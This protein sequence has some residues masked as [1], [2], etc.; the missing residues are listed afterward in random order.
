MRDKGAN[1][2]RITEKLNK[3]PSSLYRE[4]NRNIGKI[5]YCCLE[6]EEK[7]VKCALLSTQFFQGFKVIKPLPCCPD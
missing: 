1:I 4:L 5:H 7:A 2:A 6:A 3:H